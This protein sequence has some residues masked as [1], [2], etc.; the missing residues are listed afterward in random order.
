MPDETEAMALALLQLLYEAT[1][2]ELREWRTIRRLDSASAQAVNY[3]AEQGWIEI[4][5]TRG[6][7][8]TETGRQL[9]EALGRPLN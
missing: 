6:V 9:A 7:A 5:D 8:M 2:G 4:D 3:A 1:Q